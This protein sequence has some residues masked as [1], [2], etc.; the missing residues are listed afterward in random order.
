VVIAETPAVRTHFDDTCFQFFTSDDPA[1]LARALRELYYDPARAVP[2]VEAASCRYRAYSWEEQ[3]HVYSSAVLSTIP[4]RERR[5]APSPALSLNLA[6]PNYQHSA[7]EEPAVAV[8][9]APSWGHSP[10]LAVTEW[11]GVVTPIE[12]RG[13]YMSG[14][15]KPV[16]ESAI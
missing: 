8:E 10:A 7:L 11:G 3:R 1:D 5:I 2:M 15:S 13:V 16:E 14:M 6:E 4:Q 12:E 9:A